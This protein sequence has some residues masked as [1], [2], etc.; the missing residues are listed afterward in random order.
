MPKTVSLRIRRYLYLLQSYSLFILRN[1]VLSYP[2]QI[3]IQ[4]IS[5]CNGH[6]SFCPYPVMSKKLTQGVMPE[7][8]F[9]KIINELLKVP[10]TTNFTFELHNEPLLDNRVFEYIKYIKLNGHKQCSIVT[11]GQLLNKFKIEDIVASKLNNLTISL[12]AYTSETYRSICGLDFDRIMDNISLMLSNSYLRKRLGLS[13]VITEQ[14]VDEISQAINYWHQ[15]GVRTRTLE[16]LNRA[17]TLPNYESMKL[18]KKAPSPS[19]S[20]KFGRKVVNTIISLT[21]CYEA[22]HKIVILFNGDVILCC[23][24]WNRTTVLGNVKESSINEIWNSPKMNET[25]R[26]ILKKKYSQIE[27]CKNCTL[28]K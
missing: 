9:Y 10:L 17:G 6:C 4:T 15:R 28:A 16:L 1:K 8:L 24:D 21:G 14:T 22:F 26:L 23:H 7:D 20:K 11:N 18:R 19:F 2:R 3:Q 27:C 12:N 5:S 25:R 13:F